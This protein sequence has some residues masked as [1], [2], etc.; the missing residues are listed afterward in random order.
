M[1]F[2]DYTSEFKVNNPNLPIHMFTLEHNENDANCADDNTNNSNNDN[3]N[4]NS[5]NN[6]NNNNNNKCQGWKED[7]N[8]EQHNQEDETYEQD[9]QDEQDTQVEMKGGEIDYTNEDILRLLDE[10]CNLSTDEKEWLMNQGCETEEEVFTK[11]RD[12]L[13]CRHN[14]K[15]A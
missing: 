3:N 4:N 9:E 5:N 14:R 8:K 12:L 11:C 7:E 15:I 2:D 6:N 13:N 1:S 10:P